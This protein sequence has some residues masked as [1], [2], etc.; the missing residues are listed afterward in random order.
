VKA[1]TTYD[2]LPPVKK[3]TIGVD[4]AISQADTADYTA[5]VAVALCDD[6][7]FYVIRMMYGRWLFNETMEKAYAMYTDLR[8]DFPN[9]VPKLGIEDVAYQ[10]VAIEEMVRRYHIPVKPMRHGGQDKRS[11]LEVLS[12]YFEGKQILFP[13]RGVDDLKDQLLGFGIEA[14]DDLVDAFEMAMRQLID[15]P[16]VQIVGM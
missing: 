9:T 14:H 2:V 3:I 16:R 8:K 1:I 12:P 15:R 10:R 5:I 13:V 11:R 4:L 6:G 7:K